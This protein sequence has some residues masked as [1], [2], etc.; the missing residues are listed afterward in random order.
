M[1]RTHSPTCARVAVVVVVVAADPT[2]LGSVVTDSD[3]NVKSNSIFLGSRPVDIDPSIAD[4]R[5]DM[6][7]AQVSLPLKG[8]LLVYARGLYR[9]AH[10]HAVVGGWVGGCEREREGR[11]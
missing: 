2:L 7:T 3:G 4:D 8:Q 10:A 6:N 9:F 11:I 1:L 5:H